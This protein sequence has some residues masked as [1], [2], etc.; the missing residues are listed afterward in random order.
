MILLGK[1]QAACYQII[2]GNI[3]IS[4]DEFN[5]ICPV[6]SRPVI[7]YHNSKVHKPVVDNMPKFRPILF[8][9]NTPGYN[10]ATFVIPILEPVTHNI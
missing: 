9:I 6:V 7:I 4:K 3:K 10:L 2:C 5:N 8:A 1:I